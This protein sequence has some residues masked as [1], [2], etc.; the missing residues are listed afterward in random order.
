MALKIASTF[1][2]I[3]GS[4][5][6]V[7]HRSMVFALNLSERLSTPVGSWRGGARRMEGGVA[8]EKN[9]QRPHTSCSMTHDNLLTGPTII[10]AQFTRVAYLRQAELEGIPRELSKFDFKAPISACRISTSEQAPHPTAGRQSS[11]QAVNLSNTRPKWIT[12][13]TI[14]I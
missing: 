8:E 6:S 1:S 3:R 11:P 13:A 12:A 2:I 7:C 4:S 5:S 9:R 10:H 14:W